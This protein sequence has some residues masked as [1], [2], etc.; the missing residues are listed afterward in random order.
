MIP[1]WVWWNCPCEWT[2]RWI[3]TFVRW[4]C[5]A[6]YIRRC[7]KVISSH[8]LPVEPSST[9]YP[10][11]C[12]NLFT[13]VDYTHRACRHYSIHTHLP[14]SCLPA[15]LPVFF[16]SSF[17]S[18][19]CQICIRSRVNESWVWSASP[20]FLLMPFD[21][22]LIRSKAVVVSLCHACWHVFT[23]ILKKV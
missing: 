7:G 5:L 1:C 4:W 18:L 21:Q 12:I 14:D 20:L 13:P 9:T 6:D 15:C 2:E 16:L 17:L 22:G 19:W 10:C 3:N 23:G 8:C 11:T